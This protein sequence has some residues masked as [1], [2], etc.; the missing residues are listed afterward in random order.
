LGLF[1]WLSSKRHHII[2]QM[3]MHFT[4]QPTDWPIVYLQTVVK[5]LG[6][7]EEGTRHTENSENSDPHTENI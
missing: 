6:L 5:A 7:R 4:V 2:P 1:S 3:L